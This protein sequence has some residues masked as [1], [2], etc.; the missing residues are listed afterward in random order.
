VKYR[1]TAF[2]ILLTLLG[3]G[4]RREEAKKPTAAPPFDQT[5]FINFMLATTL[6][7]TELGASAARRGHGPEVRQLGTDMHREQ[8]QVRNEF[9][10]VAQK[11]GLPVTNAIEARKAALRDN[12]A[13]IQYPHFD[14]GYVLA[15][16]QDLNAEVA[17]CTTAAAQGDADVKACAARVLPVLRNR[18]KVATVLL[19]KMGGNPFGYPPGQS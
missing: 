17:Q 19:D 14:R 8:A 15:M 9:A 5:K 6:S 13:Q 12:L 16:V 2:L 3:A 4:C 7:D 1:C 18:Q 11:K 10:A